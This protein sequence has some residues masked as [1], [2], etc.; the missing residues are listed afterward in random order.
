MKIF[1]RISTVIIILPLVLYFF[2]P[3][4]T[5]V[6]LA[7]DYWFLFILVF[8]SYFVLFYIEKFKR[9]NPLNKW[10]DAYKH[11]PTIDKHDYSGFLS[12]NCIVML[13]DKGTQLISYYNFDTDTWHT[14]DSKVFK[15]NEIQAFFEYKI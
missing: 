1:F 9:K 5:L 6:K 12:N 15:S 10:K 3:G 13:K 7:V 14:Y 11:K 2:Y 8:L 4:L